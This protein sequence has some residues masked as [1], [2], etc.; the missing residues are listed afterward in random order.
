MYIC[1]N[2]D[3]IDL[4]SDLFRLFNYVYRVYLQA[5]NYLLDHRKWIYFRLVNRSMESDSLL[6][7][8]NLLE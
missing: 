7:F 5:D 8:T 1:Y 6:Y 3:L 2:I 4:I